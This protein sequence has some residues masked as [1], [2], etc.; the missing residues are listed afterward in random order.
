MKE[1]LFEKHP[2]WKGLGIIG[3]ADA[4]LAALG[5]R[6]GYQLVV[7][8]FILTI[9]IL[10]VYF[11]NRIGKLEER[12]KPLENKEKVYNHENKQGMNM[13]KK[14]LSQ[15]AWLLIIILIIILLYF[16]FKKPF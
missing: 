2:L 16:L 13:N 9:V 7:I 6:K 11:D 4:I 8:T 12:M 14:G 10:I 3:L 1:G 5:F 15:L